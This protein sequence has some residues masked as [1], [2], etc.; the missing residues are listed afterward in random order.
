MKELWRK[1]FEL[2][3]AELIL[4]VPCTCAAILTLLLMRLQ[5]MWIHGI[6]LWLS[7]EHYRS[8]LGGEVVAHDM[9]DLQHR[10][11]IYS[12]PLSLVKDAVE[13][14]A[15]VLALAVTGKIVGMIVEERRT[16]L[17]AAWHEVA[18]EW[19]EILLLSAKYIL[20][21]GAMGALLMLLS[22][23]ATISLRYAEILASKAFIYPFSVVAIGSIGWVL[24]PSAMRLL[25]APR[26]F[27]VSS[28]ARK[29]GTLL[30][31]LVSA[32]ALALQNLVNWAEGGRELRQPYRGIC[33]FSGKHHRRK[34]SRG[35]SVHC[36]GTTCA[37]RDG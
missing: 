8:A 5:K 19:R 7:T 31:V 15:F 10:A 25:Q 17:R 21:L 6:L 23:S 30:T 34:C 2:L 13:V 16:N 20:G 22:A 28:Y 24:M 29:L 36:I 3:R 11:L 1:S 37:A 26:V 12:I 33:L 9:S 18:P 35:V 14:A 4:W 27:P 32:V